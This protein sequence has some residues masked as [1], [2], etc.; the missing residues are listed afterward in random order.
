MDLNEDSKDLSS[1]EVRDAVPARDVE[2]IISQLNLV[3]CKTCKSRTA[4]LAHE[5]RRNQS[6][7][8]WRVRLS[9]VAQHHESTLVYRADWLRESS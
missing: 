6:N 8:Y 3:T 2:A 7:Y 1:D 4:P 9:C 5:L